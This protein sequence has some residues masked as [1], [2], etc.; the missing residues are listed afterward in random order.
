LLNQPN[1]TKQWYRAAPLLVAAAS[2]A[3]CG[4]DPAKKP[5]SPAALPKPANGFADVAKAAGITFKMEFLPGEQGEKFK[6]NLYDHG[7]GLAVGDIDGDGADDVY[8]LNQLGRNGLFRNDGKGRFSDVTAASGT[9]LG[10]R[11][12]LAASFGDIDSDG[13]QDLY[14][15]STR[16]GNVLFRND[17]GCRFTDA[18]DAAGLKLVA[19]SQSA[20][21][22]D[23]DSDGDLDLFVTN[24][25]KW[26]RETRDRGN[27]YFEGADGLY[28]LAESPVEHNV[29]YRNDGKGVFADVTVAAGVAGP[30]WGGDMAVFDFDADGRQ[31]LLVGNMFGSSTLYRNR[32]D[33][34]FEDVTRAA[35]GRTSWGAVGVKAFDYDNDGRL[36]LM[37]ADMH[38]DMWMGINPSMPEIEEARKY[39]SAAGPMVERGKMSKEEAQKIVDKLTVRAD[40]VVFGNTLFRNLGGGKF[41]EVSDRAGAE[42]FWPWG[43][44]NADFDCDGFQDAFVPTGMG[45]PLFYWRNYLLMNQGDGTFRDRSR[46]LGV[47][48]PAGGQYLDVMIGGQL[49]AKSSRAAA[50]ADFDTDGRPDLVVA[51]Y[52]DRASLLR[53]ELPMK[54]W[55]ELRLT[56]TKSNRDAIGALV[57][58][59]AGGRL[60]VRQVD[61]AGGYLAQ[62]SKTVHFGL[63]D[64]AKADSCEIRWPSGQVQKFDVRVDALTLVTEPSQR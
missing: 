52:N 15:T 48:P 58:L 62:S 35:L 14:V 18:T 45:Y 64:A 38:S 21:F 16:G 49:C 4:D 10:D 56:G 39:A 24:T 37:L 53:N 47:E 25:A 12:C 23:Y 42:T 13:D 17:G 28:Q 31:D 60:M 9:G 26:T 41:E 30:G 3:A 33:G 40:Q 57:T 51:N 59:R 50:V 2:I 61:S 32:G 5:D 36:D 1:S 22:F 11:V 54:H 19:H 46:D 43:V 34:T 20:A 55:V 27:R 6:I 8:F 7:T 44:A 63:G 29:L